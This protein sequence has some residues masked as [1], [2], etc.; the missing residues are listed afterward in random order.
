[1]K[2]RRQKEY[3]TDISFTKNTG[4]I[5]TNENELYLD[6]L[7]LKDILENED[8]NIVGRNIVYD[9]QTSQIHIGGPHKFKRN[10]KSCKESFK[11]PIPR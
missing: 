5:H 2:L 10:E 7:D 1:M 9:E 4:T 3:I 8:G 11:G 6:H